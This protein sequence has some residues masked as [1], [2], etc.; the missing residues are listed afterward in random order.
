MVQGMVYRPRARVNSSL[1]ASWSPLTL[2]SQ[3]LSYEV[4]LITV[5]L[6]IRN[7]KGDRRRA[8][9]LLPLA[10]LW[11]VDKF[12]RQEAGLAL[13]SSP[14]GSG[15]N[16]SPLNTVLSQYVIPGLLAL[17]LILAQFGSPLTMSWKALSL[18][19]GLS[20][21]WMFRD[22]CSGVDEAGLEWL[23]NSSSSSLPIPY[24]L[25]YVFLYSRPQSYLHSTKRWFKYNGVW[26]GIAG[27]VAFLV[28]STPALF[29]IFIGAWAIESVVLTNSKIQFSQVQSLETDRLLRTQVLA[30][31]DKTREATRPSHHPALPAPHP[32]PPPPP[33]RS[34][35]LV[36]SPPPPPPAVAHTPAP[37]IPAPAPRFSS[38][39]SS[40]SRLHSG[41]GVGGG[42]NGGAGRLGSLRVN[43]TWLPEQNRLVPVGGGKGASPPPF[44][45]RSI[46]RPMPRLNSY[47]GAGGGAGAGGGG[48]G[49][50]GGIRHTRPAPSIPRS[51]S[52]KF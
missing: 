32:P 16:C 26:I 22:S 25:L 21:F 12:V 31:E 17:A 23:S 39:S 13:N 10:I 3:V 8:F 4:L 33:L 45:S 46:M 28:P 14:N 20:L 19:M 50:G 42:G 1:W 47:G 7:R 51:V 5:Y 29:H 2:A 34:S 35:F 24:T 6:F 11:W 48:G 36:H 52:F 43:G 49:G 15:S 9:A 30:K 37:A 38:Y 44:L 27:V 18:V 40:S 41:G